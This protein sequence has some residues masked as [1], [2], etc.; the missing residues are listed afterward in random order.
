[1]C[2]NKNNDEKKR[3]YPLSP[4]TPV[5]VFSIAEKLLSL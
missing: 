2:T 1:M 3:T 5:T 4:S